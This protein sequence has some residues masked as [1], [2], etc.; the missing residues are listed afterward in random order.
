MSAL[1]ANSLMATVTSPM[2]SLEEISGNVPNPD[3]S[4]TGEV[5]VTVA[6]GT[7][8]EHAIT[9]VVTL[10]L[11][12]TVTVGG[13]MPVVRLITDWLTVSS[14]WN[15][16]EPNAA[17]AAITAVVLLTL[18]FIAGEGKLATH[19]IT[20]VVIPAPVFTVRDG[21]LTETGRTLGVAVA[22]TT[23]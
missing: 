20:L 12:V 13:G 7:L 3:I 14:V 18:R 10:T 17:L 9:L 22:F 21:K 4:S 5:A 19:A 11:D 8:T 15:T 2:I 6:D 16:G 1:D 23:D